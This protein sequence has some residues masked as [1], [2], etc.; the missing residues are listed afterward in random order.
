MDLNTLFLLDSAY[1]SM[2]MSYVEFYFVFIVIEAYIRI[3][4]T[5][6]KPF[7]WNVIMHFGNIGFLSLFLYRI[8]LSHLTESIIAFLYVALIA[9]FVRS[10]IE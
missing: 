9:Y 2:I 8:Y 7:A 6:Y 5:C 10:L 3:T 4:R 1:K